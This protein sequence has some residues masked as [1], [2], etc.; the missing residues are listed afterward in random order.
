MPMPGN[1]ISLEVIGRFREKYM[2]FRLAAGPAH[3]GFGV[4]DQVRRIDDTRL[5]QRQEP[6][7]YCGRVAAG[8]SN[9][10]SAPDARAVELGKTVNRLLEEV[11]ARMRHPVPFLPGSRTLE[12]KIGRQIDDPGTSLQQARRLLHRHSRRAWQR[13][14]H[15]KRQDPWPPGPR[16]RGRCCRGGWETSPQPACPTSLRDVIATRRTC[17]CRARIRNSST[18]V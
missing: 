2:D 11:R 1:R 16:S 4:G 15:H 5:D 14:P 6:Q 7:L 18:P 3:A 9:H 17:G 13:T 8:V 10:A 12:P